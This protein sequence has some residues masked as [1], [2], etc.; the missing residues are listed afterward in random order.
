[1]VIP[2][3]VG[4]EKSIQALEAAMEADK[5]HHAGGAEDR[6]TWTSPRPTTCTDIGTLATILQMLKLPD[7]TVKVLVE[8]VSARRDRRASNDGEL[9]TPPTSRRAA[10]RSAIDQR[11]IEALRRAVDQQFE[12]YV[13]LNKKMPPEMLDL[14]RRH[15]RCR[16]P[17]RHRRRAPGAEARGQAG[18]ARDRRRAASAS[19]HAARRRSKARSTSCRSKSASAAASSARWRRASASTT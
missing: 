15:R 13:K 4:R 1:M 3:F 5:Q 11:E 6:P 12:Q 19:R 8:G 10:E 2:L 7:G 17:G 16:P 9:S 18:S 14:A